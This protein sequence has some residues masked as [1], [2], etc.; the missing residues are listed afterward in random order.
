[1]QHEALHDA[2]RASEES[3]AKYVDLYDFAPV[4]YITINDKGLI[5]EINLTGAALLKAERKMLRLK[6]FARFVKPADADRY[7]AHFFGALKTVEKATCELGLLLGD[8]THVDVRLDS[9]RLI[10]DGQTP[11]LRVVLTD[12]TERRRAE[13]QLRESELRWKFA[14]EGSGAGVWDWNIQTGDATL[15]T[16]WKEMLGYTESEIGNNA[17]EWS[18]RVHPDDLPAAMAAI[19]AHMEGKTATSSSEFRMRCKDGRWIWT[20][21][22][23]MVVSRSADGMPLRLVGTQE[24]IT[25]RKQ[26]EA[27]LV[28]A[29][30]A[31]ETANV[32]KSRF[33]AAASHDLRQPMQAI[34]LFTEALVRTDLTAEQKRISG[35]LSQSTQSL[36]D[37]LNTLLDISKLDA[38]VIK[39]RAEVIAVD[40]LASKIDAEFSPI[41]AE[42]SLR[43]KL[44]FPFREMALLTDGKLLM[45]LLGN[46]IGNAI[47]YTSQGGI[48]VAIRRRDHQALIQVWDTGIGIDAEHLDA[49]YEEYFQIGNVERD[50]KKGLGLGLAVVKRIAKLLETD[51]V[52]RSR[53]GRGSVFEFRLPLTEPVAKEAPGRIDPITIPAKPAGRHIVLVENDWMVGTATQLALESCGMT[54]TRYKTAEEALADSGVADADFYISDLRLPGLSGVEFLDAVQRR[55][56]KPIKAVVVT[57]DMVVNHNEL[58]RSTSWQVLLKPVEL[59]NLLTAL[60]S[61]DSAH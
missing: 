29:K 15:S 57:G 25:E 38:G 50:R 61:Q 5:D 21:G 53:Q 30:T 52:C 48:L 1:M 28:A 55:A 24:D 58:M 16:R 37:L 22:R 47:K 54:V 14:L 46:L 35:Y 20:L 49:I 6:P 9:L 8:G 23:G 10:K 36:G 44:S 42:K 31:A 11:A 2:Q 12:I 39:A 56:T 19:Q 32:T 17:Q 45:S 27:E 4:G 40:A 41:A 18:S 51:V 3:S 26:A 13:E 33:L 60:E 59:Q 7:H 43:F 34:S